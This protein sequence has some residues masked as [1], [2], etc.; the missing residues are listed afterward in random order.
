MVFYFIFDYLI[1]RIV[2]IVN[3]HRCT[4]Y[5]KRE[6]IIYEK[7]MEMVASILKMNGDGGSVP[8]DKGKMKRRGVGSNNGKQR[9]ENKRGSIGI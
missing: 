4:I 6:V 3:M 5:T 8:L 9:G 2:H 7:G 1:L